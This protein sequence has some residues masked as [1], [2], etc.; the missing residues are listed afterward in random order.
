MTMLGL[1]KPNTALEPGNRFEK[2]G[3]WGSVWTVEEIFQPPGLPHHARL[4]DINTGR[5]MTVAE[6]VLRDPDCFAAL[7]ILP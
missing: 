7:G 2:V 3:L 6:S 1:R 4:V 5:R